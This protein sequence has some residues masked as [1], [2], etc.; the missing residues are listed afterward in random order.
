MCVILCLHGRYSTYYMY[1]KTD[2]LYMHV[3]TASVNSINGEGVG[4]ESG[5]EMR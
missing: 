1:M 2:T 4:R 5:R 3:F